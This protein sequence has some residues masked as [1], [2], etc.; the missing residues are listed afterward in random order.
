MPACLPG[1]PGGTVVQ[2]HITHPR[3]GDLAIVLLGPDGKGYKLKA[4]DKTDTGA[5]VDQTSPVPVTPDSLG[6]TTWQLQVQDVV[7]GE[8]GALAYRVIAR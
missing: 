4:A 2:V 6:S 8:A 1:R 3:R 7:T 5:D